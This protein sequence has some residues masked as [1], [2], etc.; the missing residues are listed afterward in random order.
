[1]VIQPWAYENKNYNEL[2]TL[3][4]ILRLVMESEKNKMILLLPCFS[5]Y[6][7]SFIT[8]QFTYYTTIH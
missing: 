1:M 4:I 7:N 6:F 5:H 2:Y 3:K 8:I